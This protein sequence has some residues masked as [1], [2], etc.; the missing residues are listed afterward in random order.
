MILTADQLESKCELLIG[1]LTAVDET[2]ELKSPR[3][4]VIKWTLN[5]IL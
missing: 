2:S 5:V 1:H 4:S 3:I